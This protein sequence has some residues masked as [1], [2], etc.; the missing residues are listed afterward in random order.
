MKNLSFYL[1]QASLIMGIV[2]ATIALLLT[3]ERFIAVFFP[4]IFHN[5]R[6]KIPIFLIICP[7]LCHFLFDQYI[8]FGFC[9]NV[10]D[11]PLDCDNFVC[12]FNECYQKYWE[13]HDPVV[14]S[15]I[16]TVSVL[17][18]IRLFIW[19]NSKQRFCKVSRRDN[20]NF[21]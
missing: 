21:F 1:L 7:I 16:E 12:T 3:L 9:G 19:K 15:L 14:F 4:I 11:V 5:N 17:L 2:R 8:L 10:V 20:F 13:T 6:R 18:F